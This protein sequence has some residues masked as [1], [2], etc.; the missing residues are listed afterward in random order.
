MMSQLSKI[1]IFLLLMFTLAFAGETGK[2]AGQILDKATGEPLVGANVIINGKWE[3]GQEIKLDQGYGASTDADG[4]YFILNIPPGKY[5]VEVVYI[6]FAT[7]RIINVQVLVDKTTRLDFG[8]TSEVIAGSAMEVIAYKPEAVEKDVTATKIS[9]DI[10]DIQDLP[11][12]TDI[13][14]VLNLQAD[15]D[16]GHFRGSRSGEA[17]YLINGASIVN[18]L[19]NS[20][21]FQ[22]MTIGLEQVEVYTS[23]FSAEY[24]NVQSGVI[25]MVAKEGRSDKWETSLDISSTNSYYKT[26]GGSVFSPDYNDYFT[27]LNNT[28]EWA[29]GTDPI[30][31]VLL[32]SHFGLGF[33]RYLPNAPIVFPPQPISREDSLRTAELVRILW[34]QSVRQ[35]GLEY[36]KPDYRV[37]FSSSG[38]IAK[39]MTLFV[40][41][42]QQIV[43]PFLPTGRSNVARQ[44]ATNITYK[45]GSSDK[46]QIVYNHD[47]G[48]QNGITS[49]YFRWFENILN[50]TKQSN[51]THQFGLNWNHV[52]NPS[53]FLDVKVSQLF[54][55]N[56]DKIDLLGDS[57]FTEL[58]TNSINW[59]DYTAPTGYQVGKLQTSNGFEKTRTFTL[60]ASL[61]SQLNKNNLL[62]AGL[63]FH[64]YNIN[65]NFL[66]SRSNLSQVRVENYHEFPFEGAIYAQDKLEFE[67]LI[68][69][70][71]AR[72]DFYDFN[73]EYFTNK[74]SPYRNPN[75]DAAD[76][77]QGSFYDETLADKKE[78][79]LRTFLQPRIGISFPVSE[80]VV[81]HLNYGVFTQ[82]PPF[83][84]IFVDRLKLDANPNY[85]WLGNPQLEPERTISYDVGLVYG[86]PLGFYLD[87]SSYLKDISNLLQFA[88]YEDNGG[89]RYFT[90]DNRE[91]ANVKGFQVNLEKNQGLVRGYVR[92]NWESA[93][94]KSGSAIG[95]GARSEF[96]ENDAVGDILPSP[97]DI[98][99]DYN[100]KHKLVANLR[101]STNKESGF[102]VSGF[103]PLANMSLSGTYRF[104]SGRPFTWDPSGQGLQMNRRTPVENDLKLRLDKEVPFNNTKVKFYLEAFNVLNKKNFSY[105]RTFEDPQGG[106]NVFKQKF[107]EDRENLLTQTD[108]APYFTSLDAYLY[109]NQ[110]RHYRFGIEFGF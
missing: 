108:F 70:I 24:G 107:I 82:R 60:N 16:N 63:Q 74:F 110:P 55:N 90:F 3:D 54:T 75:F 22:P 8:L 62:K 101:L 15:V 34:L 61:S 59:R 106:Q 95:S 27:R 31:G 83:E 12:I 99:L 98:F 42:Q 51:T 91:Y 37:E 66:R 11:G 47:S 33:D 76:P 20:T 13:G 10:G 26:F 71:G 93:K 21:S 46:I 84:R 53:T 23:G 32:W 18:P 43:Q 6:G 29:F 7:S 45:P 44:L 30:S 73:T 85:D 92:Y 105:T 89:N 19:T 49:N 52:I 78:T 58:Y 109:S 2:I 80:K 67:G 28:E 87:V 39:N 50:V 81:L 94:G 38:P 96:F 17:L 68:A 4:T 103:R 5:S 86:L 9:Y 25:N 79:S 88:V 69:N 100:R 64:S 65:V 97:K 102:E 56:E 14:D 77:E 41:A 40:A 104:S 1:I 36:D 57:T 48:F 72:F 35:V